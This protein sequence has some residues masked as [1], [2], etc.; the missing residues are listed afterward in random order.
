MYG[1]LPDEPAESIETEYTDSYSM[2]NWWGQEIFITAQ[3]DKELLKIKITKDNKSV[4]FIA[5][6]SY[7]G[8][9]E[10][11]EKGE[12]LRTKL[13]PEYD[14][15]YPVLIMIGF[16][17]A[18]EKEYLTGRGY[19]VIEFNN[20]VIAADDMSRAGIF[21]ELYPYGRSGRSK[22]LLAS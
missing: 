5:I 11:N 17:G 9:T 7:P 13:P 18:K 12:E 8:K 15:G 2:K 1:V 20:T 6:I 10:V 22:Q 21:Y 16:L 19:A 4:S 3:P 14:G